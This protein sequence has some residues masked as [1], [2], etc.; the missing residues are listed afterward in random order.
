MKLNTE[1]SPESINDLNDK[2][3]DG[4][5]LSNDEKLA[6]I[7]FERYRIAKLNAAASDAEFKFVYLKIRAMANLSSYKFFLDNDI[8]QLC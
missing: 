1:I 7:N 8:S 4:L 3:F 2:Y 5:S 6:L